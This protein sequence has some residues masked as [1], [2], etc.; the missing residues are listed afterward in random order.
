MK[1]S[2]VIPMYNEESIVATTLGTVSE[3][4][5]ANFTDW[6]VVFSDDGSTV[7]FGK[8]NIRQL[9]ELLK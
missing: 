7:T 6:E 3:Y 9:I 2:L 5:S 4:M 8:K 1:V